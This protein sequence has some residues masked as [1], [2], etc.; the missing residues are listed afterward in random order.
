MEDKAYCAYKLIVNG[1]DSIP[2]RLMEEALQ[3]LMEQ[4]GEDCLVTLE[5]LETS[6]ITS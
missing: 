6:S 4:R 2:R 3:E 5:F 1:V